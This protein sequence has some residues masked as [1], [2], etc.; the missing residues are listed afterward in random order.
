LYLFAIYKSPKSK[1]ML[2]NIIHATAICGM[3]FTMTGCD[4]ND[5]SQLTDADGNTYA[6]VVIGTQEWMAENLRTKRF[7]NG[8][9]IPNVTDQ[10]L[11]SDLNV[12]PAWVYYNDDSLHDPHYGKLYN[13]YAVADE[14]KVCPV[15]WHVPSDTEW[16]VLTDY[17][18]GESEAGGKLKSTGT[19]FWNSPNTYAT[20]ESGFS[21]LPGGI[22]VFNGVFTTMGT[23]AYWWSSSESEFEAGSW[24]RHIK[25]G[26]A[27]VYRTHSDQRNGLS[28]R[29][30]KD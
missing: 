27:P 17:L 3:A 16:T 1:I 5:D 19:E 21:G 13:W 28:V 8:D 11:W 15:G 2:K 7:A 10:V 20:N 30:V 23:F 26:F 6:T 14:R 29:C 24:S 18:G 9:P 22:C 12:G 25:Y 4:D